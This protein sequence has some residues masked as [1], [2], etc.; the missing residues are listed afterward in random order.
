MYRELI[1]EKQADFEAAFQW[2]HD[3]AASIRTGRATPDLVDDIEVDYHGSKL[4]IKEL[5]AISVPEPRS[6]AIQPWDKGAL[7]PIEK[8]IRESQ[9]GLA[10]VTDGTAVRLTVPSLTEERRKEYVRLLNQKM[11]EARIRV[12]HVREEILKKVQSAVREK[13]AREDDL[14]K[15]KEEL[16]KVVDDVNGR[17]EELKEQKERELMTS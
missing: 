2:A 13:T 12:R 5:A 3:E 11:E 9:L 16:Q 17:I 15:A 4:T 10:P 7:A 1:K 8:A 6:I 14:R